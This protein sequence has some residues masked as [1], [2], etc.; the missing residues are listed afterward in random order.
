MSR[1]LDRVRTAS[2]RV[3]LTGTAITAVAFAVIAVV[4]VFYVNQTLT[5]QVDNRLQSSLS[6]IQSNVAAL[7]QIPLNGLQDPGGSLYGPRLLGWVV[8]PDGSVRGSDPTADL[9]TSVENVTS[10]RSVVIQ[11]TEVRVAG[12]AINGGYV[13]VGQTLASVSQARS[14]V[15]VAELIVGAALLVVVFFGAL[16]VGR[17]VGA[18]I[19]LARQRQLEFTADASHELRTPL[20]VIEAQTSLALAQDREPAWYQ[21]AFQRVGGES[22]RIRRL[23]EDLLWL[24]RVDAPG[25]E[26][27][28]EPVD[29][30]LLATQAVDRFTS[31]AEARRQQLTVVVSDPS[32][33]ISAS[34]EWLDRLLGVL[35]DNACKYAPEQGRITVGVAAEGNRVRLVVEDSGPGIP[36][37]ERHRIFDRF[38]R[39]SELPGAGLGLAIAD[40][41]VRLTHGRWEIGS[42][43]QFG[44]ASM[45]VSWARVLGGGREPATRP[46]PIQQA[47][48]AP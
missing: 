18:P 10:P 47:A 28:P 48:P 22:K 6:S 41:V 35:L 11:G 14:T 38:H 19:E 17:R 36:S 3:A 7:R 44:G 40:A 34:S 12:A 1:R 26:A 21:Q 45:A 46:A 31:V 30:G 29:V 15:I 43:A 27:H 4:V 23:V 16:A 8:L 24:A 33:V 20:S 9:P 13:I 5:S 37:H 25:S 39:A 42:S 2:M 32:P